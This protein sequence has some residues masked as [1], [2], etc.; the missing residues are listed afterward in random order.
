MIKWRFVK[1]RGRGT[2]QNAFLRMSYASLRVCLRRLAPVRWNPSPWRQWQ[3]TWRSCHVLETHWQHR[4]C[5][6]LTHR[7]SGSRAHAN[8]QL[9]RAGPRFGDWITSAASG[10]S[11]QCEA[12]AAPYRS[13]KHRTPACPVS[14]L[15]HLRLPR[16]AGSGLSLRRSTPYSGGPAHRW[17]N[18]QWA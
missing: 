1:F 17:P 2:P 9:P 18:Q 14:D 12:P 8:I 11:G 6:S 4:H 5:P 13:V 15:W 10:R 7:G 3:Q 16:L